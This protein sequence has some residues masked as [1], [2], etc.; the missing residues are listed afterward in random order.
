MKKTNKKNL[1]IA[2]FIALSVIVSGVFFDKGVFA[3]IPVGSGYQYE[4]LVGNKGIDHSISKIATMSNG[5]SIV[6]DRG[7]SPI[8]IY[9]L[10]RDGRFKSIIKAPE[11]SPYWNPSDISVDKD[12]NIY[13]ADTYRGQIRKLDQNGNYISS[14][15]TYGSANNQLYRPRDVSIDDSGNIFVLDNADSTSISSHKIKI[16]N[17]NGD[18]L[19]S[20]GAYNGNSLD[21]IRNSYNIEVTN[22][23]VYITDTYARA[24]KVFT[25]TGTYVRSISNNSIGTQSEISIVGDKVYL[26]TSTSNITTYSVLDGSQILFTSVDTNKYINAISVADDGKITAVFDYKFY[27]LINGSEIES[28][29]EINLNNEESIFDPRSMSTDKQGNIY[30]LDNKRIENYDESGGYKEFIKIFKF[31]PSRQL[32]DVN[33]ILIR[34]TDNYGDGFYV[35]DIRNITVA[36]NGDLY[37]SSNVDI[38]SGQGTE[39]RRFAA[40]NYG[41]MSIGR[42]VKYLG[43]NNDGNVWAEGIKVDSNNDVYLSGGSMYNPDTGST[44]SVATI[45]SD[46]KVEYLL[47]SSQDNESEQTNINTYSKIAMKDNKIYMAGSYYN[48]NKTSNETIEASFFSYDLIAKKIEP[49]IYTTTRTDTEEV[50][51][52]FYGID[53]DDRGNFYM[54]GSYSINNLVTDNYQE[55]SI[56]KYDTSSEIQMIVKQGEN[57]EDLQPSGYGAFSVDRFGNIFALDGSIMVTKQYATPARIPSVPQDTTASV[58]GGQATVNWK[59][60]VDDGNS[61]ITKYIIQY[62]IS[63]TDPWVAIEVNGDVYSYMI[64]G[65]DSDS[66]YD[67]RISAVNRIGS[68]EFVYIIVRNDYEIPSDEIKVPNTGIRK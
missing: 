64:D 45:N 47:E 50:S 20:F 30:I 57:I 62:R 67:I 41:D 23:E 53:M 3:A 6:L 12:D 52:Y 19:R 15:G 51:S 66:Q 36:D 31:S 13:V 38:I 29:T 65:L 18:F 49:L 21:S 7:A 58:S 68:S 9:K 43:E 61:V 11:I 55:Y 34:D 39:Y 25:N 54:V 16:F 4:G 60:P 14:I 48:Y 27:G 40:V 17:Q 8:D 44:Y 5:D 26:N 22:S 2:S 56:V 1:F 63:G 10:S 33:K 24:I 37:T 32:I 42:P 59:Q 46:N 35:N 28:Q